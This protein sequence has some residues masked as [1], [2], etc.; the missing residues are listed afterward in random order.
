MLRQNPRIVII[1][2]TF[3]HSKEALGKLTRDI[4]DAAPEVFIVAGGPFVYFSYR[5]LQRLGSP[6]YEFDRIKDEFIFIDYRDDPSVDL[7]VV[8]LRGED[9]LAEIMERLEKCRSMDDL[10]NIARWTEK[11]YFFGNRV[12]DTAKRPD[13]VVDW[14]KLPDSVFQ[15]GVISLDASSGCPYNCYF[16]SFI[17]DRSLAFSKPVNRIVEDLKAVSARG[18]Q[19]VWFV[20]DNFRLGAGNLNAFCSRLLKEN[21]RVKWMSFIRASA[22]REVD[23]ELLRNAGCIE[24]QLGLESADP[25]VLKNMNKKA[26]AALYS[27][28]IRELLAAGINCSCYFIFG[29]PGET[30]ES[31]KRT[32][33]FIES[34]EHPELDGTVSWSMF[35]F[36]LY[37]LSPIYEQAL[38]EQY[39][40]KG[41]IYDW[42]HATMTSGQARQHV[43]DTFLRLENS[44]VIYRGDDQELLSRLSPAQKKG[45]VTKRHKLSKL[46]LSTPLDNIRVLSEFREIFPNE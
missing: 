10:P 1:S 35:P 20:D 6:Y 26:D 25:Q 21:I 19:Y 37:P 29:Y 45:F 18:I 34:I 9:L 3:I 31:V 27:N 4:R 16:C 24:V 17:R 44:G 39:K 42:E 23:F 32:R 7:Y 38:R 30:V 2:T 8:S 41:F 28:V 46:A 11:G 12:E 15:S 40:L 43:L 33:D 5:M 13:T 22:L 36:V 14:A